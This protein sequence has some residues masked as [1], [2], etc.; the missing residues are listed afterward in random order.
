MPR[1][2]L[3]SGREAIHILEKKFGCWQGGQKG[4]HVSMKRKWGNGIVGGTIPLHD[5][6]DRDTLANALRQLHIDK[7]EFI[8]AWKES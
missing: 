6:L 3:M 4:S 5:E 8:K 1:L 7:D 2:P